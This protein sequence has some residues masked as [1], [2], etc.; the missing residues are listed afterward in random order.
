MADSLIFIRVNTVFQ[1]SLILCILY[2]NQNS[3]LILVVL[4]SLFYFFFRPWDLAKILIFTIAT[5]FF[6]GQNYAVLK[7]GGFSFKQQDFL[8]MPYYEPFLWGFYYLNIKR[9]FSEQVSDLPLLGIKG[10][11]GLFATGIAFSMFSGSSQSLLIA[12]LISTVF[13][14]VLFHSPLDFAYGG[15]ALFLGLVVELTGVSAGLWSYPAPDFLGIP[16]WFAT[17]WISVGVLGRHF[18][19]PLSELIARKIKKEQFG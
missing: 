10:F 11:I 14:L 16:F 13:V 8:L 17:M 4:L 6:L 9:F 7:T 3:L 18:L 2:F 5:I 19:Y 15:Y 12:S 1:L